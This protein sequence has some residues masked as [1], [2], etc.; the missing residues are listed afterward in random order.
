M[1]PHFE[2]PTPSPVHVRLVSPVVLGTSRDPAALRSLEHP[3]LRVSR[4]KITH[5]PATVESELEDGLALP[6]TVNLVVAAEREGC[7]AV[8]IDCM[9]DPGLQAAREAVAIPVLGPCET[10]M[11]L[12]ASLGHRFTVVTALARGRVMFAS[13]AERYGCAT[14][15]ASVRAVDM[16][17]MDLDGNRERMADA[18]AASALAA[19]RADDADVIL[20]G[21]TGMFGAAAGLRAALLA[22]GHDVPVIDPVPATVQVAAALVF[23][24][25]AHSKAA[26][27]PPPRGKAMPGYEWVLAP[28]E[29]RRVA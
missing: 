29:R 5:G 23:A 28:A 27:P 6:A 7:D 8:V 22:A 25:L 26:Y 10:G 13:R 3:G 14:R 24:G 2:S 18:L 11:H 16:A 20:L 15:L 12:A 9:G 21:C 17:V 19:V 1:T 4:S